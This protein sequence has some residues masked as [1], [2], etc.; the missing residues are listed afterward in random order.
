[1]LVVFVRVVVKT[2]HFNCQAGTQH[3]IWTQESYMLTCC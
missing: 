3:R 2:S 1:M